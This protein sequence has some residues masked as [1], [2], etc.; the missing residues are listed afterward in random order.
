MQS[1][2]ISVPETNVHFLT[3]GEIMQHCN[4]QPNDPYT[5]VLAEKLRSKSFSLINGENL[6]SRLLI[7]YIGNV[8]ENIII[9][10]I[11]EVKNLYFVMPHTIINEMIS[12][13]YNMIIEKLYAFLIHTYN[14]EQLFKAFDFKII[15][16]LPFDIDFN[17]CYKYG[18]SNT[19]ILGNTLPPSQNNWYH[20]NV[21][22][23]QYHAQHR[24]HRIEKTE[25]VEKTKSMK[26][27]Q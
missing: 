7:A 26:M 3:L 27:T 13:D 2:N 1:V 17:G 21:K 16:S 15:I 9:Y 19:N 18:P 11:H 22:L 10:E 4:A 25:K 6:L 20:Y 12:H 8:P 23:N 24:K 5:V 14:S